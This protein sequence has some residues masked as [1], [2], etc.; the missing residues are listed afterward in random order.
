M[1]NERQK[2]VDKINARIRRLVKDGV[3]R[4]KITK[5]LSKID[6]VTITSKGNINIDAAH[7][8]EKIQTKLNESVATKK[9]FRDYS[10]HE[11]IQAVYDLGLDTEKFRWAT[12]KLYNPM[13]YDEAFGEYDE[14]EDMWGDIPTF[15]RDIDEMVSSRVDDAQAMVDKAS[16]FEEQE[17]TLI[18]Q[19]MKRARALWGDD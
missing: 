14:D 5:R 6:G 2:F 10:L 18:E 13:E 9:T 17:N 19:G 12:H 3:N 4:E 11:K 16:K 8:G 1:K 7:F 15:L